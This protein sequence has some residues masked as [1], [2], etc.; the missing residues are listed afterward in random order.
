MLQKNVGL[1]YICTP[2]G[3]AKVK[4]ATKLFCQ[5]TCLFG[6]KLKKIKKKI[7]NL[8]VSW[9]FQILTGAN[10]TKNHDCPT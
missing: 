4:K 8:T 5:K 2:V 1:G 6:L 9:I 3:T 10:I 7:E